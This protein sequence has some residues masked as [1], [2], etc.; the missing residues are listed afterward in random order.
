MSTKRGMAAILDLGENRARS[1]HPDTLNTKFFTFVKRLVDSGFPTKPNGYEEPQTKAVKA[2][3]TKDAGHKLTRKDS[4]VLMMVNTHAML[5]F[6]VTMFENPIML[7]ETFI[8]A[9][10]TCTYCNK[11]S[12]GVSHIFI[13]T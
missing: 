13:S 8:S 9:Y 1:N 7:D 10:D 4:E 2:I 3:T 11:A 12:L 6:L 5:P